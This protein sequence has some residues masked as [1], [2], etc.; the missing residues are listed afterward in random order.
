[1]QSYNSALTMFLKSQRSRKIHHK[2]CLIKKNEKRWHT[3]KKTAT[4]EWTSQSKQKKK[5]RKRANEQR[6]LL[7]RS[8]CICVIRKKW[9]LVE[10]KQNKMRN[11]LSRA[12]AY[13]PRLCTI[14][15]LFVVPTHWAAP[16]A[17]AK[18]DHQ[19]RLALSNAHSF[20]N[21]I[22]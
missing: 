22:F 5:H 10:E 4:L 13:A 2:L 8:S 11:P 14:Q 18:F 21:R 17:I 1:M 3:E 19:H 15:L 6:M 9:N 20:K 12:C 16:K 7:F